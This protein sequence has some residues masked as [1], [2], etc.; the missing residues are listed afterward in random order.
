MASSTQPQNAAPATPW[1][2]VAGAIICILGFAYV[3]FVIARA[4]VE[5]VMG[6]IQKIFYFHVPCAWLLLLSTLVA[7]FASLAYLFRGSARGD[8]VALA[9][10]ELGALFGIAALVSGPLWGRVAWGKFWTWDARQT[11]TLLLWLV[12]LAY[13]LARKYGGPAARKLAAALALF[14]AADVPLVYVS[15]RIWRTLHPDNSV[16][17]SLD[18][19]M[20]PA[21]WL[22]LLFFTILWGVLLAFRLRLEELRASLTELHVAIE[23]A[24]ESRT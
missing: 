1:A 13:L 21:F 23:D 16:V 15:V 19:G 20:R 6:P 14:A 9:A 12:L 7:G 5:A 2:L 24:E 17:K 22:S 8:R 4:P 11:S 10:A 18:P 3:P